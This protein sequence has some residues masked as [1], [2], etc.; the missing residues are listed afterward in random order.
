MSTTVSSDHSSVFF[1]YI[2]V[3]KY[4]TSVDNMAKTK[5]TPQ[6]T[7]TDKTKQFI[8]TVDEALET[9]E[10]EISSLSETT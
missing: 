1:I 2:S 9:F 3:G 4:Q 10:E 7:Q 6:A 5:L 8:I